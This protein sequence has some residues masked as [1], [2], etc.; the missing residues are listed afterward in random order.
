[1]SNVSGT[2][3]SA[4]CPIFGY[5]KE[6]SW[7]VLP[8][9]EDVMKYYQYVRLDMKQGREPSLKAIATV[10]V[11][12]LENLWKYASI[13]HLS[14]KRIT[15]ML[16]QYRTKMNNLLKS[17]SKGS[18]N[19]KNKL[20]TMQ[21]SA[22]K[23][24]FDISAC[25]CSDFKLCNCK[26]ENQVPLAER[27][28]LSDQRSSRC[29]AI[30]RVDKA[31]TRA[32]QKRNERKIARA[33]QYLCPST[34]DETFAETSIDEVPSASESEESS[35]EEYDDHG[36]PPQAK[37]KK[38]NVLD[39]S[40]LAEACDRTGFS[41]RTA[42]FLASSVLQDAG[43]ITK[44]DATS[45]IDKN[46]VQ[47]ARKKARTNNL[48]SSNTALHLKSLYF[49]GR[50]DQTLSQRE[51]DG[52]L[53]QRTVVEEHITLLNEPQSQYV[54]HFTTASGSSQSIFNG[55]I[56]HLDSKEISIGEVTA[57]GCD[58]TAVN[59]G[60]NGGVIKLLEEHLD[61]PLQW[62][63]CLLHTNELPLRHLMKELDGGTSGPENFAGLVGKRLACCEELDIVDFKAVSATKITIDESDLSWDQKYLLSMFNSIRNGSVPTHLA[64][65]K[66]GL[67]NHS[68]WL[69]TASRILRLYVATS[70]PSSVLTD[71]VQYIMNV[72]IPVWFS[73]KK[74]NNF[75]EGARHFFKL[76]NFS[77]NLTKRIR[78]VVNKVLQR[79]AFFAHPE[80]IL[81]AMLFD[82]EEHVRELGW[83]RVL[84]TRISATTKR[85]TF[86][87]LKLLL[88]SQKYYEMIDWQCTAISEPP[89]L[90][91]ISN[92]VIENHIKSRMLPHTSCRKSSKTCD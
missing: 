49:D 1:M 5:P 44:K 84:K 35:G 33:K 28:F 31:T 59:T 51:I 12:Q 4:E 82:D 18:K 22:Q 80:N 30:D 67:I 29:M 66:P 61:K 64:L 65:Q 92:V 38:R 3:S 43:V 40:A 68:R 74:H 9:Y 71:L 48:A 53:H 14:R 27:A 16:R 39:I 76:L 41:H 89:V 55:M 56:A 47:R 42:A 70:Q 13:P 11:I 72:Y 17:K 75:T 91:R 2:R 54:G 8:T 45:V 21:D 10:V 79:N 57:I 15:G 62:I 6:I 60:R 90:K 63:I 88:N 81:I 87:V 36:M 50:R 26:R 37:R 7:R 32:N 78:D 73:V 20:K 83:R 86:I 46:K 23:T 24:L 85:R 25:K 19:Y 34:A 77:R 52:R 69:T 58:G